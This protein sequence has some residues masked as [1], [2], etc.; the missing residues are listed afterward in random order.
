MKKN[1]MAA[2]ILFIS[3]HAIADLQVFISPP[4]W[5]MR[6]STTK[7][8]E[9]YLSDIK[10]NQSFIADDAMTNEIK[11]F[12]NRYREVLKKKIS[13]KIDTKNTGNAKTICE[14]L[15]A[16]A[17]S[18]IQDKS[19]PEILLWRDEA[20]NQSELCIITSQKIQTLLDEDISLKYP[21]KLKERGVYGIRMI[22]VFDGEK[23]SS[24]SLTH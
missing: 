15:I 5:I 24:Q 21:R 7:N 1:I 12:T 11:K 20:D 23:Q 4:T 13:T 6:S 17:K 19:P 14:I 2:T 8:I 18:P 3:S 16:T 9:E 22:F 10:Y